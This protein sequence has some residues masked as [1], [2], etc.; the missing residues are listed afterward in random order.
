MLANFS[1]TM[2]SM[3]GLGQV[4]HLDVEVKALE[5]V[6]HVEGKGLHIAE[7]VFADVVLVA[8]QFFDVQG[9]GVV[10]QQPGLFEQK[11]LGVDP[12]GLTFLFLGQHGFLGGLQHA[13]QPPQHR[14]GQDHA[15][16]LGLLVVAPQ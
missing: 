12:D 2:Y 9:R 16:V 8:H 13:V 11:R 5:D 15:T 7:Q 14:E 1:V 3:V 6:P 10:E 4:F